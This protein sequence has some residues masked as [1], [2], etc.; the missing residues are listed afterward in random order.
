MSKKTTPTYCLVID[1][2][3]ARAAGSLE[4]TSQ[5]GIIC[6]DVLIAV[7]GVCHRI[8]W[9]K[10]ISAEWDEHAAKS[11]FARTWLVSMMNLNKVRPVAP[12]ETGLAEGIEA[13][14]VEAAV[15]AILHKDRHLVEA[16][17]ETDSRI[18]SLDKTARKHFVT[19]A[20]TITTLKPILWTNPETEE[21]AVQWLE[22]GAPD[23]KKLRLRRR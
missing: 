23:Q 10:A 13:C 14:Q 6:R 9:S 18:I 3:V 4:A 20:M 19:I 17:L 12:P 21:G 15:K 7:R 1:A 11:V 8:A 22:D 16:A 2:D 5:R